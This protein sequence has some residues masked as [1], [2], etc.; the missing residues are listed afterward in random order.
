MLRVLYILNRGKHRLDAYLSR[1][2][3]NIK[4]YRANA[5][6]PDQGVQWL[7][8]EYDPNNTGGYFV[9][10][11]VSETLTYDTWHMDLN[12]ALEC[13]EQYGINASDWEAV[14]E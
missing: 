12:D 4:L 6:V 14:V 11:H 13:G 2:L 3:S 5:T 7:E 9:F 8:I 1:V 10:Y